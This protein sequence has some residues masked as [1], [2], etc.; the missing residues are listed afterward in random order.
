MQAPQRKSA[1]F[2]LS[3]LGESREFSS[4]GLI[5]LNRA[6]RPPED[7]ETARRYEAIENDV[8]IDS[9]TRIALAQNIL[10]RGRD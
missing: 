4:S 1:W 9:Q 6:M 5:V 7:L 2:L 3:S 10:R 8:Q